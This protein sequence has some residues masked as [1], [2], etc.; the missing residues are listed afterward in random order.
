[1]KLLY[2]ILFILSVFS[3]ENNFEYYYKKATEDYRNNVIGS[4]NYDLALN[5]CPDIKK[6]PKLLVYKGIDLFF[7]NKPILAIKYLELAKIYTKNTYDKIL[8]INNLALFYHEV[9]QDDK[10]YLY[11]KETLKKALE[12]KDTFFINDSKFNILLYE[13]DFIKPKPPLTK[14]WNFYND[15]KNKSD[16]ERFEYLNIFFELNNEKYSNEESQKIRKHIYKNFKIDSFENDVVGYFYQN[17]AVLELNLSNFN[18]S[19]KYVDSSYAISKKHLGTEE[20][21]ID[22]NTYKKIYK[23]KNDLETALKYADSISIIE[24]QLKKDNLDIGIEI[25][26]E[27]ILFNKT[28]QK[29]ETKISNFRIIILVVFGVTILIF[30]FFFLKNKKQKT[31]L[32]KL[33]S[34]LIIN[35]GKYN[36][37]LKS[38]LNFKTE[39]KALLEENKFEDLKKIQRKYEIEDLNTEIYL[40]YLVSEIDENFINKLESYKIDFNDLEKLLLYYRKNKHTYKEISLITNRTLRSIQGLSYR[41]NK[42]ITLKTSLNLSS[43]IEK[44]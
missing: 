3:S 33:N 35:K 23:G 22:L 19:L 26:N 41:L 42:K 29:T 37:T 16:A 36:K 2:T 10:A 34:Q 17:S 4:Q 9:G 24:N 14:F 27:N 43:F 8:I 20:V 32:K 12:A 39:I 30:I 44:L 31:R 6:Y 40:E 15:L 21:L 25:V 7:L 11:Y 38:N 13:Y 5:A 18:K 1:M 28:L